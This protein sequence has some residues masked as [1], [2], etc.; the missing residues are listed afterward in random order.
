MASPDP[1]ISFDRRSVLSDHSSLNTVDEINHEH[2]I[3]EDLKNTQPT[4]EMR[5]NKTN[6]NP[7]R[8]FIPVSRNHGVCPHRSTYN[9]PIQHSLMKPDSY[10]GTRCFEQHMSHFE[11]CAELSYWDNRTKVLVLESSLCGAVRNC[12]MSLSESERRDYETLT[13][14][15]SQRFGS[16]KHQNL[17]LS[18]FENRRRMRGESIAS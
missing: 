3:T 18:N 10:D 2:T 8:S 11:D 17:W 14:R 5:K 6:N 1:E 7:F 9:V 13:S 4:S 16:S 15:L 12:Y